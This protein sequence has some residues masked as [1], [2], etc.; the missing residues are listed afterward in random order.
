MSLPSHR[1]QR[2]EPL[3]LASVPLLLATVPLLRSGAWAPIDV[4]RLLQVL[5]L[6]IAGFCWALS[7]RRSGLAMPRVARHALVLWLLLA[8][9]SA[10][11]AAQTPAALQEIAL[12]VGCLIFMDLMRRCDVR[13]S[14]LWV[15]RSVALGA[16]MYASVV[17]LVFAAATASGDSLYISSFVFGFDNYRFLSHSQTVILPLLAVAAASDPQQRWRRS[18]FV[19]LV[20]Q[21][22]L[23]VL[24]RGRATMLGVAMAALA[25]VWLF[26]KPDAARLAR[27]LAW[28]A[29][30][31][32]LVYWV[33][34]QGLPALLGLPW[35]ERA[36]PAASLGSGQERL[37]LWAH[38]L[39]SAWRSPWLGIG[40]M[41]YAALHLDPGA[42]PHN[43]YLQ[44]L[45]E[46]GVMAGALMVVALLRVIY[47]GAQRLRAERQPTVFA[48]GVWIACTGAVL[49]G[50]LSGNF[51]MPLS[52]CWIAFA[53]GL[54]LH[55][56]QSPTV[57]LANGGQ[58]AVV[59]AVGLMFVLGL[60]AKVAADLGK[61]PPYAGEALQYT[62]PDKSLDPRFWLHG[63]I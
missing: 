59:T 12:L 34:L 26:R 25:A 49:D 17:L 52:Q 51:V 41:H 15:S 14:A 13:R 22:A 29:L 5:G 33:V 53:F 50:L 46:Y 32:T 23:L 3:V 48:L 45:A 4:Q 6:L 35:L 39:Q 54:L 62:A 11:S 38:A 60:S 47:V 37:L 9:A 30:G 2:A 8:L 1:H 20:L 18:A 31:G 19:V 55:L 61:D 63:R 57:G 56:T 43:I 44:W 27:T 24:T 58:S 42:H 7:I 16:G 10:A 40:P 36:D 21:I 28:A